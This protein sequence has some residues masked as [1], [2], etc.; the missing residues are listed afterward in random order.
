MALPS[1]VTQSGMPA[2]LHGHVHTGT[3]DRTLFPNAAALI[4]LA[5]AGSI[6]VN[7]QAGTPIALGATS[8]GVLIPLA[9]ADV[10]LANSADQVLILW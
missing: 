8:V 4:V 6:A 3:T 7:T 2:Y 9:L 10:E 5:A 1:Q